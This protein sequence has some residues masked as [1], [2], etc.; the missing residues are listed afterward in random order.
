MQL[1]I[2]QKHPWKQV[3]D[4]FSALSAEDRYG[5]LWTHRP[6]TNPVR[7]FSN[8]IRFQPEDFYS[9]KETIDA[10]RTPSDSFAHP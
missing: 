8:R 3:L 2:S 6:E 4:W 9:R 10:I 1:R 5:F 7:A